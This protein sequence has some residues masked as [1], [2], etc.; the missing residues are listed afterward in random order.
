[1]AAAVENPPAIDAIREKEDNSSIVA[2]ITELP[3]GMEPMFHQQIAMGNFGTNGP[4]VPQP[5]MPQPGMMAGASASVF[6]NP[7]RFDRDF[8]ERHPSRNASQISRFQAAMDSKPAYS[9]ISD[10]DGERIL[11]N[12]R[13]W[14]LP[15]GMTADEC[16]KS[17]GTP[18]DFGLYTEYVVVDTKENEGLELGKIRFNS[19][20]GDEPMDGVRVSDLLAICEDRLA[21]GQ[22]S[23]LGHQQLGEALRHVQNALVCIHRYNVDMC[24]AEKNAMLN[25]QDNLPIDTTSSGRVVTGNDK[26]VL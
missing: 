2:T 26:S 18:D 13:P 17:I 24:I 22:E 20:Q 14:P 11:N 5:F 15:P 19:A 7:P 4:G 6:G 8:S 23:V 9:R 3:G 25:T 12:A 1:M 16:V 21:L 10:Q